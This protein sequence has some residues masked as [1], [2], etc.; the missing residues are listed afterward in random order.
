MFH[1]HDIKNKFLGFSLCPELSISNGNVNYDV[2]QPREP[3][4]VATYSCSGGYMLQGER[5]RTCGRD[6]QWSGEEPK[7][8][9]T[10]NKLFV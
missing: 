9:A 1:M 8:K 5:T 2:D 7:C 10:Q 6:G 3:D 4:T